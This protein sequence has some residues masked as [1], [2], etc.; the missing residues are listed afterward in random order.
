MW[1]L[2]RRAK[3][4]VYDIRN[5]G[6]VGSKTWGARS[7]ATK[8]CK[9][10]AFPARRFARPSPAVGAFD[11]GVVAFLFPPFP[12]ASLILSCPLSFLII[13]IRYSV[14]GK[15]LARA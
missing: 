12:N 7:E 15:I 11:L 3:G 4:R 6:G 5:G 2:L 10:W 9:Y 14:T 1:R 13:S 8:R